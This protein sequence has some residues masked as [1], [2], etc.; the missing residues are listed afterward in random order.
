MNS[1]LKNTLKTCA[2]LNLNEKKI[3][4]VL[5]EVA[6]NDVH[7]SGLEVEYQKTKKTYTSAFNFRP[8]EK[9]SA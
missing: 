3:H 7:G 2:T 9:I 5:H 8:G 6:V 4:V 1:L